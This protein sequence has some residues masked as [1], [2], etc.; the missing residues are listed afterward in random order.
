MWMMNLEF[1]SDLNLSHILSQSL[2]LQKMM[3]FSTL[4]DK[5]IEQKTHKNIPQKDYIP[6]YSNPYYTIKATD[7]NNMNHTYI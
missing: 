7:Y 6:V 3:H 4:D 2:P 5:R 1:N